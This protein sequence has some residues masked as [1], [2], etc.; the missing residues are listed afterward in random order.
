[1]AVGKSFDEPVDL[2]LLDI[3]KYCDRHGKRRVAS[4]KLDS[5]PI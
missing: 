5:R 3:A 4:A 1:M 2:R